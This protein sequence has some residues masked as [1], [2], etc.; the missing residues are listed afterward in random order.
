MEMSTAEPASLTTPV[1]CTATMYGSTMTE[2]SCLDASKRE[3]KIISFT[4]NV[5]NLT[6][7]TCEQLFCVSR[8]NTIRAVPLVRWL[9]TKTRTTMSGHQINPLLATCIVLRWMAI[10][11]RLCDLKRF[12]GKHAHLSKI[13]FESLRQLTY[14]CRDAVKSPNT[15]ALIAHHEHS[16]TFALYEKNGYMDDS[17]VFNKRMMISLARPGCPYVMQLVL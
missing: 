1:I 13:Y 15:S 14:T 3:I 5:L 8:H 16:Y 10:S 4:N 11:N 9:S 7:F 6:D 17:V 2:V 12:F